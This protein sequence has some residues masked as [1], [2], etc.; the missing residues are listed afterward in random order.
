METAEDI[1]DDT[2]SEEECRAY[3][4]NFLNRRHKQNKLYEEKLF[5]LKPNYWTT[6]TYDD[7]KETA[8]TFEKRIMMVFNNLSARKGWKVIGGWENG[9]EGD[10]SHFH[11]FIFVPKGQMIGEL[12]CKR[13]YSRKK[14]KVEYYTDNTYFFDRFGISDWV[15]I[16]KKDLLSGRLRK[17]LVKY[18]FKSGRRLFYSRG[19]PNE[20]E[21]DIDT[22]NDVFMSYYNYGVH[23]LLNQEIFTNDRLFSI[24]EENEEDTFIFDSESLYVGFN[25]NVL[26]LATVY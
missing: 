3:Y 25:D 6:F 23:H 20:I 7:K 4:N 16:D 8:E 5:M 21:L 15:S 1:I 12:V 17:Y 9:E 14:R 24:E 10:R 2:I 26:E 11:A 13:R 19:I 18:M 22:D